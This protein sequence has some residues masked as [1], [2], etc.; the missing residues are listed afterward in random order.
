MTPTPESVVTR[1]ATPRQLAAVLNAG[2]PP[3]PPVDV[4]APDLPA[5]PPP[6]VV[7]VR[8]RLAA[9]ESVPMLHFVLGQEHMLA[10]LA[11]VREAIDVPTVHPV[12]HPAVHTRGVMA[13]RGRLVPAR[14]VSRL[15]AVPAASGGVALVVAQGDE[16][17]ALL[18]D[19][20]LD[21]VAVHHRDI[22]PLP[23]GA[24]RDGL[25]VGA[26]PVGNCLA[27]VLDIPAVVAAL[28]PSAP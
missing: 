28:D 15:L 13:V 1:T 4:S 26:V 5:P 8:D 19:D 22:R 20:V 24:A 2:A 7:P 3:L 14:D 27:L 21:A 6:P 11:D 12:P 16:R 23:H 9:G 25:A 10:A 18:A 17:L